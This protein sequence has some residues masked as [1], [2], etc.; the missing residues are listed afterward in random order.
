VLTRNEAGRPLRMTAA[1][2]GIT[3]RKQL[4]REVLRI[5]DR[6]QWRIG[7]DLHD[8]LGQQ[9]TAIELLCE[10]MRAH[11]AEREPGL[12]PQAQ[13]LHLS[14]KTVDVHCG[15]F[16]EKLG[17]AD[18]TALVRHAVRWVETQQLPD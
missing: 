6:E 10:G 14:S 1:H 4:E 13:Q 15:R 18:G 17:C 16:K 12:V 5:S 7:Q 8:G 9:L 3:D 2:S 11:L